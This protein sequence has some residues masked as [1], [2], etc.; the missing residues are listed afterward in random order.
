MAIIN[1]DDIMRMIVD[2]LKSPADIQFSKPCDVSKSL[3]IPI[4][5]LI[6]GIFDLFAL[7][8]C[9]NYRIQFGINIPLN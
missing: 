2:D 3:M 4:N 8:S 6:R 5:Y 1:S 7:C 9:P